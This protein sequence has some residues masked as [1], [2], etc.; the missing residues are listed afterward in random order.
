MI[1]CKKSSRQSSHTGLKM[2]RCLTLDVQRRSRPMS[3]A[4]TFSHALNS[5]EPRARD[6]TVTDYWGLQWPDNC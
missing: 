3:L 6:A 4:D 2:S 5:F 1:F